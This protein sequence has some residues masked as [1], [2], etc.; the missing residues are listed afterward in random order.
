MRKIDLSTFF[1]ILLLAGCAIPLRG[2]NCD[3]AGNCYVRTGA[4]GTGT[5]ANWTNACTG[6]TGT[7]SGANLTR[8]ITYWLAG[9][10]YVTPTLNTPENGTS[11]ITIRAATVG[12]HGPAGD[13]QAGFAGQVAFDLAAIATGYWTF[14][15]QSRTGWSSSSNYNMAFSNPSNGNAA[16]IQFTAPVTGVTFQYVSFTGTN[17]PGP[18]FNDNTF[19]GPSPSNFRVAYCLLQKT[20]NT[21]VQLNNGASGAGNNDTFEYD[22]FYLNHTGRNASHDEAFSII[23][24]NLTIRY[25]VFQDI[26]S[27]GIITDAAAVNNNI[28]NWNIYGNLF[29]WDETFNN[30][31]AAFL[32]DGIIAML[33]EN[34]TGTFN[35]YNNTIANIHSNTFRP[36]GYGDI[37]PFI[38]GH[39]PGG[40]VNVNVENNITWNTCPQHMPLGPNAPPPPFTG[41]LTWDYQSYF[42][43]DTNAGDTGAHKQTSSINPFVNSSGFDFRL[44]VATAAGIALPAPYNTDLPYPGAAT[45]GVIRGA[46]GVWDR[47]A[48]EFVAG[49]PNPPLNLRVTGVQ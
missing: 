28:S 48:F 17:Q 18:N 39:G 36:C 6:L 10:S 27:T 37:A 30:S 11:V 1:V 8:G 46:D 19:A 21:Q 31:S 32:T 16:N 2:A 49:G 9:G 24:S 22:Y 41:T 23:A 47:G 3:G 34:M 25:C 12:N 15:G 40:T 29:F 38:F 42:G 45:A 26:V 44:R 35:V 5:G 33:G 4:T 7:C 20:G 14:D 43:G 13:W